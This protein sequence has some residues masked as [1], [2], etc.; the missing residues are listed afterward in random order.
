[1]RRLP[2]LERL[3]WRVQVQRA[4]WQVLV[5]EPDE[6]VQRRLQ[7][8]GAVEAMRLQN[9]RQSPVE[10]LHH[11]V[12]LRMLGLGQSVLNAQRLAQRIKLMVSAGVFLAPPE[13]PI[14]ELSAVVRQQRLDPERRRLVQRI[15]E[16]S[17]GCCGLLALDGDEHPACGAVDGHEDIAPLCL[18]LHLRQVLHVHVDVAR[19]IGFEGLDLS[20]L[21]LGLRQAIDATPSQQ[22][23]QRRAAHRR[24]KELAHHRQQVV[25][26]QAQVRAKVDDDLFLAGVERGLQP[27]RCVAAVFDRCALEPLADGELAH[28]K[29]LRQLGFG[30]LRLLNRQ[31][32]SRRGRRVLVQADK[33]HGLRCFKSASKPFRTSRPT[34]IAYRPPRS[35]S[36]GTRQLSTLSR[37]PRRE[38]A[39][40][41]AAPFRIR[42]EP[43]AIYAHD[44]PA[45]SE[46]FCQTPREI[47]G[48]DDPYSR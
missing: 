14:S 26:R 33:H 28:A 27:M 36:S 3:D 11:A 16:R 2:F 24:L 48:R 8:M 34:K 43:P 42:R 9:L 32:G 35:H 6:S 13:R 30:A 44:L 5:V 21:D 17:R 22:S 15:E 20:V 40:L 45:T 19:L 31:P 46:D 29:A 37:P 41:E 23:V 4:L 12:G 47:E 18:I 25:Q 39:I 38:P 1:M 7:V 10:A